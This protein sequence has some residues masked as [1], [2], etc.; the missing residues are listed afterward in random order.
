[1]NKKKWFRVNPALLKTVAYCNYVNYMSF[2]VGFRVMRKAP[3][4]VYYDEDRDLL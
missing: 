1:M 4:K 2:A 3:S